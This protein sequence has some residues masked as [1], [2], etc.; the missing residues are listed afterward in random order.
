MRIVQPRV[1]LLSV[2][3]DCEKLIEQAGRTCYKS[4]D[5]ITE[6]SAPRFIRMIVQR[7]HHSVLE[8]ASASLRFT[9]DRGVSHELV[10][11]RTGAYSQESTRYCNYGK[12]KFGREIKV[13]QPPFDKPEEL[14]I[15][16]A[17]MMEAEGRYLELL[18]AGATPELARSVLPNSLATEIVA[19]MNFRNWLHF[20]EL[21]CSSA[22]HPQMREVAELARDILAKTAPAVFGK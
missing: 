3:P 13:V 5:K 7:G 6:E 18:D 8:H 19:T 11:H 12:E 10:R 22:A 4:E 16:R 9:C 2:T 15:W 21:R 1:E 20:L 14:E 17:S